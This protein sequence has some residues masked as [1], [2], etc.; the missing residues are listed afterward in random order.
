MLPGY[1][2]AEA[3][4]SLRYFIEGEVEKDAKA[5]LYGLV[6]ALFSVAAFEQRDKEEIELTNGR[7]RSFKY[8]S[9]PYEA[10]CKENLSF[11]FKVLKAINYE[12][13]LHSLI[14]D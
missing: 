6:S 2:H 14:S 11:L 12:G 1:E 3:G 5:R 9:K 4:L 7:E 13:G 10:F 8:F